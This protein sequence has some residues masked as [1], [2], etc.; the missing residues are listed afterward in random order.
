MIRA[1]VRVSTSKQSL[2]GFGLVAQK[3]AIEAF[4]AATLPGDDL[5]IYEEK[6]VSGTIPLDERPEGARLLSQLSE[7]DIVIS[8]DV[9]RFGRS[10]LICQ[11][12]YKSITDLGGLVATIKNGI[13]QNSNDKFM[14]DIM[15]GMAEQERVNFLEKADAGLAAKKE[16][17]GNTGGGVPFYLT[18]NN[19]GEHYEP[20][21][22]GIEKLGRMIKLFDKG[23]MQK[24]MATILEKSPATI[25]KYK[26]RYKTGE[27]QADY[28][29]YLP[30]VTPPE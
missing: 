9:S 4:V 17:G 8:F 10:N 26:Q 14:F 24:E 28:E 11:L 29:K 7:N 22:D 30:L 3:T 1:Y 20:T 15:A 12:A 13:I 5:I 16:S 19:D 2:Y 25:S 23:V 21:V 6:A 18:S 27:L